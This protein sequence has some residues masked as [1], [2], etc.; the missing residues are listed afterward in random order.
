M[1]NRDGQAGVRRRPIGRPSPAAAAS[2]NATTG[3]RVR[4]HR[5]VAGGD[6]Y[7]LGA[8]APGEHLLCVPVAIAS[9]SRATRYHD[10][11]DRHGG[12]SHDVAEDTHRDR[13]LGPRA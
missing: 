1:Q 13:L 7:R 9:S 2:I 5:D 11:S 12:R 3:V 8:H 6:L 4:D 10:G